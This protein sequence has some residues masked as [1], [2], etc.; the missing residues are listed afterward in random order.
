MGGGGAPAQAQS[1]AWQ[2]FSQIWDDHFL[3]QPW[4]PLG[5]RA[6]DSSNWESVSAGPGGLLTRRP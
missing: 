4:R 3:L 2:L 1:P 6:Q 5:L